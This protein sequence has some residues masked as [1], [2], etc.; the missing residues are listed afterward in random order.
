MMAEYKKMGERESERMS[1]DPGGC[2]RVQKNLK[3]N[4]ENI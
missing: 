1:L 3:D 4:N 2:L